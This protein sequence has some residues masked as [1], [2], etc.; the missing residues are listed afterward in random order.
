VPGLASDQSAR[1]P[2]NDKAGGD[3]SG[4]H[5]QIAGPVPGIG[6]Q[7]RDIH[8]D[9]TVHA[10]VP[11]P[12]PRQ[13]PAPPRHWVDRQPVL[14]ALSQMIG[15]ASEPATPR[16]VG[17]S[18]PGGIGKTAAALHWLHT[19]AVP[20]YPDGQLFIDLRGQAGGEPIPPAQA[21]ERFLRALGLTAEHTPLDV[22]EQAAL[23]R[24]A[25]A[26]RRLVI[27]LDNAASV[28]QV[29]P[30]LPASGT[31]LV[32]VTSRRRLAAL[33]R[34]GA[35]LV[36]LPPL[37]EPD[38]L[39]LLKNLVGGDRL[40]AEPEHARSLIALCSR[41]PLGLSVTGARLATH[42]HLPIGRLVAD[43][44][45][46]TTPPAEDEEEDDVSVPLTDSYYNLPPAAQMMYRALGLHPGSFDV[47]AEAAAVLSGLHTD[48]SAHA[49][50]VLVDRELLQRLAGG[51]APRYRFHD[52]VRPH[53]LM[54]A[55]RIDPVE[56]REAALDRLEEWYLDGAVAAQLV[57]NPNRWYLSPLFA[58]PRRSFGFVDL[59]DGLAWLRV[60]QDNLHAIIH[61]ASRRG[62]HQIVVQFAEAI[63]G[64]VIHAKPYQFAIEVY[65]L[66]L[67]SAVALDDPVLQARM[68]HGL[69]HVYTCLHKFTE[70]DD[71]HRKAL[72]LARQGGHPLAEATS[73]EGLGVC[74]TATGDPKG[75]ITLFSQARD[76]FRR[77]DRP[78][79][80]MIMTRHIG[81]ALAAVR[82]PREA[83]LTLTQAA[84]AHKEQ[85]EPYLTA[86][87]LTPLGGV[88]IDVKRLDDADTTL[89]ESLAITQ[90]IKSRHEE[91]NV[92]R[93]LARLAEVRG[94]TD[95]RIEEL[96]RALDIYADLHAPEAEPVRRELEALLRALDNLA[97][98]R[99]DIDGD[100]R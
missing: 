60:E 83:I 47:S 74:T 3:V 78:R 67:V 86:R 12:L 80:E 17:L 34:D 82:R 22:E 2:A 72:L 30:L 56:Q 9:F 1:E 52:V 77:L 50:Q 76:I 18:G 29:R 95:T 32:V 49:L 63:W 4:W 73:L 11:L 89:H 87:A 79:G 41:V 61:A 35:L 71:H 97:D 43:L 85:R 28:R 100:D 57:I 84:A 59:L 66:G 16:L 94:D 64:L 31:C 6:V 91:A 75:G 92:H 65:I 68:H 25:T 8:G 44:E 5:N 19:T 90:S 88:F 46:L 99:G 14:Q 98:T 20:G 21:L 40:Q 42:E 48:A 53:A 7:A 36:D 27:M 96:T 24:S 15:E 54:L 38:A 39:Q 33:H 45:R 37:D 70:A 69:G 93:A 55:E 62:R 23:F 81:E 58:N 10:R 51:A 26:T 13:L